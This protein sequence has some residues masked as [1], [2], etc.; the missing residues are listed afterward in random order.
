MP[1]LLFYIFSFLTELIC[2]LLLPFV[3]LNSPFTRIE[4]LKTAKSH[5]FSIEKAKA[6]MGYVPIVSLQEGIQRA[7]VD[8]KATYY[9]SRS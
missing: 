4:A 7:A 8:F 5:S 1:V 9:A 6:H 3:A 2:F